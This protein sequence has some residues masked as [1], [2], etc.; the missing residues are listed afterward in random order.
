M[1]WMQIHWSQLRGY[2]CFARCIPLWPGPWGWAS[3]RHSVG[4]GEWLPLSLLRCVY[5]PAVL[6]SQFY[7]ILFCIIC[8]SLM[9]A[10]EVTPVDWDVPGILFSAACDWWCSVSTSGVDVPVGDSSTQSVFCGLCGLRYRKLSVT[11]R[12]QRTSSAGE[13]H[14]LFTSSNLCL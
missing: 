1:V 14:H 10:T 8:V 9:V 11:N 7:Y 6:Q 3:A 2:F 4:L 13:K 12:N 5:C